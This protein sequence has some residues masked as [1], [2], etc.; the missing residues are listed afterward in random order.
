MMDE[1]IKK[2]PLGARPNWVV[3][4]PRITELAEAIERYSKEL[5]GAD[6]I[7]YWAKEIVAQCDIILSK[8]DFVE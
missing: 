5:D 1:N 4:Y 2:P 3:A 8:G 6:L 7:K